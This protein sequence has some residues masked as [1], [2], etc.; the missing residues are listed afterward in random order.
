[1]NRFHI[2]LVSDSTGETLTAVAA[3]CMVQ[4]TESKDLRHE[5][6]WAL[7]RTPGQMERVIQGIAAS[8]GMVLFTLVDNEMR[9]M[10]QEACRNLGIPC[11]AVLDPV[12]AALSAYLGEQAQGL[13]G[14]QHQLDSHYFARIE[15]M[16]FTMAHDD[17]IGVEDLDK[18]DVVLVGVS[19]TSKTPTSIYLANRGLRTANVPLAP[20]VP[21][22][23]EL[24]VATKPL[25]VGLI[26]SPDRLIQVRRNRLQSMNE[27]R[28]TSY[29]DIETVQK[30]IA[31]AR[32]LFSRQ[33][34]P[35][36]DVTRRSIEETA[37]AIF[38]LYSR[39]EGSP[40]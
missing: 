32:K 20:G 11:I 35:V 12:L 4:F 14:R 26:T 7:V 29:V 17:G 33:G 18:S 27:E 36:I 15:A 10:L 8:R 2:H 16:Q 1:M 6:L 30:E 24:L 28:D 40:K 22:P 21:V 38:N 19:R 23:P 31:D 34:W 37:A 39:R 9:D 25:I 5:H 13:P 3:A